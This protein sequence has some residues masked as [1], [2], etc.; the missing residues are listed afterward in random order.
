MDNTPTGALGE[1]AAV[2]P[3]AKAIGL[4]DHAKLAAVLKKTFDEK[5]PDPP[6]PEQCPQDLS[7]SPEPTNA[8]AS[9]DA[10][11]AHAQASEPT[12]EPAGQDEPGEQDDAATTDD[13]HGPAEP[14]SFQKRVNKLVAAKKAAEEG[15][16]RNGGSDSVQ[17]RGLCGLG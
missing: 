7:Q 9:G 17:A 10:A 11:P 12:S 1:P 4:L 5:T 3:V 14:Q 13:A 6:A 16:P 8:D 2:T 15:L